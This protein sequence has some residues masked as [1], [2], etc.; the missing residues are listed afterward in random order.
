[1]LGPVGTL[2]HAVSM[3]EM[4]NI[5]SFGMDNMGYYVAKVYDADGWGATCNHPPGHCLT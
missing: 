2:T 4:D 3:S 1:M 5:D